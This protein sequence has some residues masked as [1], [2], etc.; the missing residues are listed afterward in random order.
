MTPFFLSRA[1]GHVEIILVC[2]S[3]RGNHLATLCVCICVHPKY[4]DEFVVVLVI[5]RCYKLHGKGKESGKLKCVIISVKNE[6]S[7]NRDGALQKNTCH[8]YSRNAH[9]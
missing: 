7:A 1:S 8:T 5:L 3:R 2:F 6:Y 4:K 9:S